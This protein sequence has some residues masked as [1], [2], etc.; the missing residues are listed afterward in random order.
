MNNVE[1]LKYLNNIVLQNIFNR[2][3]VRTFVERNIPHEDL[4]TLVKAGMS[5]P[6][7]ANRQPWTFIVL[8]RKQLLNELGESLPTGKMLFMA[9]AAIVVC[10]IPK[11]GFPEL[12]DY[13]VQDCSAAAQNILLAIESIGLG[14]VWIGIHPRPERV[15]IV[16]DVLKIPED[17]IPLNII[18]IGYPAGEEKPKDKYKP[19]NIHWDKW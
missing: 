4:E 6:S 11:K 9:S 16:C 17:V 13:W 5:A 7:A 14:G 18:A 2:R 10:G 15:K 19:D 1:N 12:T 3:S 8:T